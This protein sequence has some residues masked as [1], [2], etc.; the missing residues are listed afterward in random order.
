M[1]CI[2]WMR[3]MALLKTIIFTHRVEDIQDSAVTHCSTSMGYFGGDQ[4]DHAR[5]K[6]LSFSIKNKLKLPFEDIGY[7]FVGV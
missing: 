1:A 3:Q 5:T 4:R 7:L 6:D 2:A